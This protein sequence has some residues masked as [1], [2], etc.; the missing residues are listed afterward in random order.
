MYR[1][2]AAHAALLYPL[3]FFRL[4]SNEQGLGIKKKQ[5]DYKQVIRLFGVQYCLVF[6]LLVCILKRPQSESKYGTTQVCHRQ[7]KKFKKSFQE[8]KNWKSI[9]LT[10][11]VPQTLETLESS[12]GYA[13]KKNEN[14]I[15]NSLCSRCSKISMNMFRE[16]FVSQKDLPLC[17]MLRV[18]T[19]TCK[20]EM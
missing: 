7:I 12:K 11:A 14:K 10:S 19:R 2:L 1:R 5:L 13:M 16:E 8:I 18:L 3:C 15:K 17:F 6:S 4:R 20:S 9:P